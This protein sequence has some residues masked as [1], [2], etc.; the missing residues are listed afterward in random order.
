MVIKIA[1]ANEANRYILI[2][3]QFI[4]VQYSQTRADVCCLASFAGHFNRVTAA[5]GLVEGS[6]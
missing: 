3:S 6:L 4:F 5:D 1:K 2:H